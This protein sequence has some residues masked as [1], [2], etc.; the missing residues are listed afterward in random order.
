M[1]ENNNIIHKKIELN[2]KE[3]GIG[4]QL[5]FVINEYQTEIVIINIHSS[6][7]SGIPKSA[8]IE[9]SDGINYLCTTY[10]DQQG[11]KIIE[12]VKNKYAVD[13]VN[14]IMKI[15]KQIYLNQT[16]G[17]KPISVTIKS[18]NR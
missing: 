2:Y 15:Q 6:F 4:V 18:T 17:I 5:N 3:G 16:C 9:N 14:E 13:I 7:E 1:K 8:T 11:R 12:R 10:I